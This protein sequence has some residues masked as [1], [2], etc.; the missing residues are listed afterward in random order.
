VLP[1][2]AALGF[3]IRDIVS[4][5]GLQT[6][7]EPMIAASAATLASVVL[8]WT[9]AAAGVVPFVRP[10]LRGL[11]WVALSGVCECVAYLTMWRALAAAPVSIVSPLVHAQPQ[12][13]IVLA[14][15][16]L[17]DVERMT[18]RLVLASLLI[19]AGVTFVLRFT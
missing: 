11:G 15:I 2:L 5:H 10:P 19:V 7:P 3:A 1:V 18:W 16:F 9:L 8:M 17:R 12:F 14:A 13:T 4:R 6:Y